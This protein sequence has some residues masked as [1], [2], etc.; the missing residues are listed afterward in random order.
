VR[1]VTKGA[2][3]PFPTGQTVNPIQGIQDPEIP[4]EP[5]GEGGDDDAARARAAQ[6]QQLV[7]HSLSD[8]PSAR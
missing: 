8:R 5:E 1:T 7:Q 6:R 2:A 3:V 4:G